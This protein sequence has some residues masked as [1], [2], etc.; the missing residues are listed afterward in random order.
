MRLTGTLIHLLQ[1][2]VLCLALVLAVPLKAQET[3][4]D[5][6]TGTLPAVSAFTAAQDPKLNADQLGILLV[7]LTATE[8]S[9][10]ADVW[11]GYLRAD[12]EESAHL[13]LALLEA[14]GTQAKQLREQIA[15]ITESDGRLVPRYQLVLASWDRKGAATEDMQAHRI[16]L[17][18]VQGDLL[19]ITDVRT[20][21]HFVTAWMLSFEGGGGRSD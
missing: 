16:F 12:L 8:L 4:V 3:A 21:V 7:P 13:N 5:T 1:G 15:G 18:A 10:I 9:E 20:V 2:I 6:A 11:Q 17:S 14:D 19:R